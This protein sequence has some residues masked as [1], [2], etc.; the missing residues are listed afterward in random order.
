MREPRSQKPALNSGRKERT[1]VR[2]KANTAPSPCRPPV[3]YPSICARVGSREMST[4]RSQPARTQ[5]SRIRQEHKKKPTESNQVSR[6]SRGPQGRL[7]R[8]KRDR[9]AE[10]A[11][12]T[13]TRRKEQFCLR[14]ANVVARCT[15]DCLG[16]LSE[17]RRA[18]VQKGQRA[19]FVRRVL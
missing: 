8:G 11:L 15:D 4:L 18:D 5:I 7:P 6:K 19:S 16:W 17:A 1:S 3:T 12:S 10:C 2:S 9:A 13:A 14:E